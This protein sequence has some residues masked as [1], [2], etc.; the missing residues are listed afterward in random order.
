MHGIKRAPSYSTFGAPPPLC[1]QVL[2]LN[3]ANLTRLAVLG[4]YANQQGYIMG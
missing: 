2:P 4:P 3:P 1:L